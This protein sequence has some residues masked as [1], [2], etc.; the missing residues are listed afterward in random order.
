MGKIIPKLYDDPL[1]IGIVA[2]NKNLRCKGATTACSLEERGSKKSV[3]SRLVWH[4]S[5]INSYIKNLN[6]VK[7][8]TV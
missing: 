6:E 1:V 8:A 3:C 5:L 7:Y 2:T 4:L